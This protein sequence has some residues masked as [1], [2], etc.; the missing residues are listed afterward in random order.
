M[1][2]FRF[3]SSQNIDFIVDWQQGNPYKEIVWVC[4][5]NNDKQNTKHTKCNRTDIK[6]KNNY[7]QNLK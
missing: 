4:G 6:D 3:N 1:C 2:I 7:S 5:C